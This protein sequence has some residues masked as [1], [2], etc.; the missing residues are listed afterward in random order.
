MT[1]YYGNRLLT[2]VLGA[3]NTLTTTDAERV[4]EAFEAKLAV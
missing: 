1:H 4:E 3:K 2:Q